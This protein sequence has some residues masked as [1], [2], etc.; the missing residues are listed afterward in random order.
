[1]ALQ[2][3]L[4]VSVSGSTRQSWI[5]WDNAELSVKSQA[6]LLSLNRTGLYYKAKGPSE[7]EVQ[8]RRRIDEIYT[9]CPFYGS[10]KI[11]A[12]LCREGWRVNRKLVQRL[13]CIVSP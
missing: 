12:Q 6:E 10:R 7:Q 13:M 8:L 2:K 3:K 4:E 5:E 11:K 1:V 9:E